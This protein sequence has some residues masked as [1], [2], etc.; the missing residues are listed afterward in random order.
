M[1]LTF[2]QATNVTTPYVITITLAIISNRH[3]QW[4]QQ[5]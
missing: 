1:Q 3:Q 2:D 5:Q 4:Q